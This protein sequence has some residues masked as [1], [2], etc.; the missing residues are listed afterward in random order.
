MAYIVGLAI[1]ILFIFA[2]YSFKDIENKT[3]R[4]ILISIIIIILLAV[5][6]NKYSAY[7][8]EHITNTI[9]KFRQNK[10]I[11]CANFDVNKTNFTLSIGTY[12]FIAKKHSP[13][14]GSMV[15]VSE[16]Q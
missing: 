4:N 15:S 10:T 1:G 9:L 6:T 3:K 11:K 5:A 8:R 7:E 16:C 12:T 14:F 2:L 13:Y